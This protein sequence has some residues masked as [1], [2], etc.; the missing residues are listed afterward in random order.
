[1]NDD[2][3]LPM[4]NG[5]ARTFGA[6][7]LSAQAS[8]ATPEPLPTGNGDIVLLMVLENWVNGGSMR[9]DADL[10]LAL[11][12]RAEMGKAKYGT[13]LRTRNG[14]NAINDY[15]Q[16]QLDAIMYATQAYMEKP[17]PRSAKMIDLAVRG[18]LLEMEKE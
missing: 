18:A 6:V 1:M 4:F 8:A 9:Q 17:T 3:V 10:I 14:R 12:E 13:Y 2:T 11:I 7:Q 5:T 15:L 16:E